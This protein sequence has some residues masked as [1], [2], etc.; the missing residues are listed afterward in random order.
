[1]ANSTTRRE[2]ALRSALD[3]LNVPMMICDESQVLQPLN[4][5]ATTLFETE[6]L[7]GD[8]VAARPSHPLSRLIT[9]VLGAAAGEVTTRLVTFPSGRRYTIEASGR[10]RKGLRRW[11]VLL[12]EPM[13][14]AALDEKSALE[15]WPL[16]QREREVAALVIRGLSN[17]KIAR[18]IGV[19][20]ETVKTHVHNIFEK[21]GTH[22]RAEFLA[23]VLRTK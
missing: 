1:M 21:S 19:S 13:R 2:E 3:R 8:L 23:A 18:D 9:E 6:N 5:K 22:S 4:G 15:R 16:T 7:R 20:P 11:L 17:E 10:S 12:L 14:E